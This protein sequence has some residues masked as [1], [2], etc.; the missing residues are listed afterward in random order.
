MVALLLVLLSTLTPVATNPCPAGSEAL[1]AADLT[2]VN[3]TG[4]WEEA[5]VYGAENIAL[6]RMAW[7]EEGDI[8]E[9]NWYPVRHGVMVRSVMEGETVISTPLYPVVF[10]QITLTAHDPMQYVTWCGVGGQTV[11][12]PVWGG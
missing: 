3:D 9:I 1:A 10:G 12:V 7:D 8:V 6:S 2:V 11:F 5:F 4:D